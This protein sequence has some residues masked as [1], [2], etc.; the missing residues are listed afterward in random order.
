MDPVLLVG[1]C[2]GWCQ[3]SALGV[4]LEQYESCCADV[5]LHS[6][7][8]DDAVDTQ[9]RI[10]ANGKAHGVLR[11]PFQHALSI[12]ACKAHATK[13]IHKR[14]SISCVSTRASRVRTL[15]LYRFVPVSR[16]QH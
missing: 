10:S 5:L 12:E 16:K 2:Q 8:A 13:V 9:L 11:F 4:K 15:D 3:G 1:M 6:Y 7:G 14:R